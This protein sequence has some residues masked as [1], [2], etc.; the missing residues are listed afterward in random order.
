[1]RYVHDS[2]SIYNLEHNYFLA[3]NQ[4]VDTTLSSCR[5]NVI[6]KIYTSPFKQHPLE[7]MADM[8][9]MRTIYEHDNI[10]EGT[11]VRV[12]SQSANWAICTSDITNSTLFRIPLNYLA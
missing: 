6:P 2:H 12:L 9:I 8:Y 4:V 3:H 10:P 5:Y 1:I 11:H 7:S